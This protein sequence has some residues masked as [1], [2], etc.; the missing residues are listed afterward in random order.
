MAKIS[1]FFVLVGFATERLETRLRFDFDVESG[2]M[3]RVFGYGFLFSGLLLPLEDAS[4]I[5]RFLFIK[6]IFPLFFGCD[7]VFADMAALVASGAVATL[8]VVIKLTLRFGGNLLAIH[9]GFKIGAF[10]ALR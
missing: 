3:R 9:H 2:G 5:L 7:A 10:E 1:I 6:L 4:P 8:E